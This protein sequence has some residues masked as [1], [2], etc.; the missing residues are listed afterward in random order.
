MLMTLAGIRVM[1]FG[2]KIKRMG[3]RIKLTILRIKIVKHLQKPKK[4][5]VL[6]CDKE[7]ED[8]S[9]SELN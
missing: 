3:I 1:M 9:V 6:A 4:E 2:W 8:V 5:K 7:A